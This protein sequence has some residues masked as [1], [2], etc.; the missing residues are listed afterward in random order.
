MLNNVKMGTKL[1]GSFLFLALLILVVAVANYLFMQ[2]INNNLSALYNDQLLPIEYLSTA[3]VNLYEYRAYAFFYIALPEG[4][5][6]T[7]PELDA[8]AAALDQALKD[9][10]TQVLKDAN[11]ADESAENEA[12]LEALATV[13]EDWLAYQKVAEKVINFVDNGDM[14]SATKSMSAGGEA[15]ILRKNVSDSMENLVRLETEQAQ[16]HEREGAATFATASGISVALGVIGVVL[17]VILGIVISNS[18]TGPLNKTVTMIQEMSVGRLG[19]RLRL[20]RR[21]EIG[22]LA[23]TMDQFADELQINVIGTMKKIADGDLNI[24]VVVKD[25]RDEIGPALKQTI[26]SLRG[27]VSETSALTKSASE[28]QLS[29]RGDAARYKGAYREIVQGLNNAIGAIVGPLSASAEYVNRIAKGEIPQPIT[30]KY[31]GDFD[32]LKENMNRLSERLRAMVTEISGAASNLSAAAAEILAATSQQVAGATEQSAAI[33][34][35]TTTVDEVKTISEQAIDRAQEVVNAS[36]RTVD[37]SRSGQQSVEQTVE[38]MGLIKERV[39]GIAENIVALSDQTQQIGEIIATVNEIA[40]QSNMLALNASVEAARA[41][42]HG[43]GFAAV[44]L[45]VR[46]LAEQSRQATSQ[47]KTILQDVQNAISA[48]VM[49]TEEGTK[50]VDSGVK[51]AN[52][53]GEVI[54]QLSSA[55]TQSAQTS[56]QVVAGGRQ[57]ASGME[58]I[59][60]AM[61]NI[62]QATQQSLASTRQAE[63]AAQNL[64]ELSGKLTQLVQRYKVL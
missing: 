45:E 36:Q 20:N 12:D 23:Q 59:A 54:V 34:Q 21:D 53:T 64:N 62:N 41:G 35:T 63:K 57:Q 7:R 6:T 22:I 38:S 46:N 10:E 5:A 55:I 58:Q 28:G 24:D 50:V 33:S 49:S 13:R 16:E 39:E 43:K 44:A 52:Q 37:I 19:N 9:Y 48:A 25:S 3:Q 40:A 42:E 1:I 2:Q 27:L 61:Q 56:V 60:L 29:V 11:Q 31:Q 15:A 4:R 30:E 47:V 18:I 51:L 32:L 8:S 14:E 26:E 17:A